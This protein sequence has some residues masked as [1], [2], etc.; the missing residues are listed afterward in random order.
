LTNA[1]K[2]KGDKGERECA[3]LLAD[4]LG[5]PARRALGAGRKDDVGDVYGIPQLV[6]QVYAGTSNVVAAGVV[7]KPLEA[8]QQRI[9]AG[10]PFAVTAVRVRGGKWRF[11]LTPEQFC[12]LYREATNP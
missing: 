9:N 7:A 4:L 1:N 10:V 5:V 3:A 6:V 12:T 8:E 11:V 2:Q